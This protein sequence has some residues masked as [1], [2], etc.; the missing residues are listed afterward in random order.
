VPTDVLGSVGGDA[1]ELAAGGVRVVAPVARLAEAH[2][3]LAAA[4]R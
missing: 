2:G 1:L 3:S 4:F